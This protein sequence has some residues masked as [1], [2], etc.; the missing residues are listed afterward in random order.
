MTSQKVGDFLLELNQAGVEQLII[1]KD[2]NKVTCA[3]HF[4]AGTNVVL[5]HFH[6]KCSPAN[7]AALLVQTINNAPTSAQP[8]TT[9]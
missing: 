2:G 4:A 9:D 1:G 3:V 7:F 8:L 5:N 6:I